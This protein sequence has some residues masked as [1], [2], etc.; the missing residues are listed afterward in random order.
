[1]GHLVLALQ[2]G[3]VMV[4]GFGLR[5]GVCLENMPQALQ[6]KDPLMAACAVQE[7]V[8]SRAPGFGA[9]L[10]DWVVQVVPPLDAVEERLV[11]ATARLVDVNWRAHPD[12]RVNGCWEAVT[13]TTI[14][15]AG[16]AGR[17]FMGMLLAA[18]YK[19]ARR[20]LEISD[21]PR[22]L[23]E[24]TRKRA[25]CYGSAFRLGAVLCGS[26]PGL[27]ADCSVMRTPD[28]LELVLGDTAAGFIGE[29][30]EKRFGQLLRE[31]K[32]EGTLRPG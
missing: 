30:V 27:L 29:E 32:I 1:M 26:T 4:S 14:T 12:Y 10:A 5:E 16:H 24:A 15:D 9:E 13:R 3:D 23:D 17:A 31:L 7:T 8:R 22:L 19:R 11:R 25:L 2:P 6:G 20:A 21:M 28:R 18:R